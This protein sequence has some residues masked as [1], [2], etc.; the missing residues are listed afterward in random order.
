MILFIALQSFPV[1]NTLIMATILKHNQRE[2]KEDPDKIDPY[3]LCSD[4]SRFKSGLKPKN[5]NFN[6]IAKKWKKLT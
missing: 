6:Q 1:S 2:F 4:T 3:R 5:L